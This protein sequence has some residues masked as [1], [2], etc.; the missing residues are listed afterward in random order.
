M[1]SLVPSSEA[2]G[3]AVL[4]IDFDVP[5]KRV[6]VAT[7]ALVFTSSARVLER[8]R[9][10]RDIPFALPAYVSLITVSIGYNAIAT[11]PVL[12][13]VQVHI[14]VRGTSDP[15]AVAQ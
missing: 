14:I 7:D 6:V 3:R 10:S 2:R 8:S 12:F 1:Q 13:V 15:R 11:C 5:D 9:Y 4:P